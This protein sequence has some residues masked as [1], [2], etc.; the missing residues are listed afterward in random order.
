METFHKTL[1]MTLRF[2][3]N[4]NEKLS[5]HAKYITNTFTYLGT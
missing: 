2:D 4:K 5:I 3:L 1:S